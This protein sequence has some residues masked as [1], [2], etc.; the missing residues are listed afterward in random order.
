MHDLGLDAETP[1]DR[2]VDFVPGE[3]LVAGDVEDLAERLLVA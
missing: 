2:R 3:A 1:G